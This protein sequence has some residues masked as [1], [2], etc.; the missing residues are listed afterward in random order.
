M[1]A[2]W[3]FIATLVIACV[4]IV[5]RRRRHH[6]WLLWRGSGGSTTEGLTPARRGT[7]LVL[8]PRRQTECPWCAGT[9][10]RPGRRVPRWL[11]SFLPRQD[12][13]I[14]CRVC[15][16]T[17]QARRPFSTTRRVDLPIGG[18]GGVERC[19][20]VEPRAAVRAGPSAAGLVPG[21]IVLL[22]RVDVGV[23]GGWPNL[24]AVGPPAAAA[25]ATPGL[26][27]HGAAA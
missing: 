24:G 1:D 18:F 10:L 4:A 12:R 11:L 8:C 20:G 26:V 16:G 21:A 13:M 27:W 7:K 17:G 14:P 22:S 19:H 9:G 25:T 6:D 23:G 2:I 15:D 5:L 3:I